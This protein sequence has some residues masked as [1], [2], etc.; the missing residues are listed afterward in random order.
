MSKKIEFF[1]YE[2]INTK[3]DKKLIGEVF[4]FKKVKTKGG[5]GDGG[6]KPGS[7]NKI[8][9]SKLSNKVDNLTDNLSKLAKIVTDGFERQE[10]F[11]TRM[12]KEVSNLR[13]DLNR[14]VKLNN[15]KH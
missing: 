12:E 11:N 9:L 1:K 14:I 3:K 6:R 4:D 13:S 7:T 2:V 8:T 10:K 5:P 15:L